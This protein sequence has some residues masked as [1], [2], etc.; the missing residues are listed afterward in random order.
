MNGLL[1]ANKWRQTDGTK[2]SADAAA[3]K[4][5]DSA[6][7][8]SERKQLYIAQGIMKPRAEAEAEKQR[9]AD[10]QRSKLLKLA[11]LAALYTTSMQRVVADMEW[12][13]L[14]QQVFPERWCNVESQENVVKMRSCAQ[15]A[16]LEQRRLQAAS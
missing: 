16:Y 5:R 2:L 10:I 3:N 9:K 7:R 12:L 6:K 8:A 1:S 11:P 13:A 14:R 15:S 4:W